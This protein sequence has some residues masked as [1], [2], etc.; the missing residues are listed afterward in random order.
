V[1]AT[2]AILL[3]IHSFSTVVEIL[4]LWMGDGV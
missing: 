2:A 4:D 1:G 3:R